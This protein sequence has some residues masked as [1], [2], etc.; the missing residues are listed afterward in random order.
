[1]K[2]DS[3]YSVTQPDDFIF[4]WKIIKILDGEVPDKD[5]ITGP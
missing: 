4:R 2:S 1:M 3:E 5:V